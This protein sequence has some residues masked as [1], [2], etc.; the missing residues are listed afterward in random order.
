MVPP[1]NRHRN[2]TSSATALLLAALLHMGCAAPLTSTLLP[3]SHD[4]DT[5]VEPHAPVDPN[6]HSPRANAVRK[7]TGQQPQSQQEAFAGVLKELQEI[8]AIDPDAERQLMADLQEAKPEHYPMIVDAFRTALAYRQQLV[9][10]EQ[11][12][13]AAAE[14]LVVSDADPMVQTA[15]HQSPESARESAERA[16]A[17]QASLAS[18]R[19]DRTARRQEMLAESKGDLHA[20]DTRAANLQRLPVPETSTTPE[21]A[22]LRPAPTARALTPLETSPSD[23]VASDPGPQDAAIASDQT[24]QPQQNWQTDLEAS[25]AQLQRTVSPQP[26]S[27][28]E[29]HDHMRLRTLQLLAGRDEEA[30]RPIPGASPDQQDYW[31]KQLFAMDAYLDSGGKLDDKQRAAAAL[32]ALD[33]ARAKLSELAT[34]QIRNA[35]FVASV[36]GFGAYEPSK[37]KSFQ[38][39]Q[40]VT[41]YAEVEN[42]RSSADEEGYYTS[43]ATSYQVLDKTG[44]RVDGKQFPDVSDRCRNRRRDFHMQYELPLPTRIYPGEYVLELTIT[45]HNSGKIGQTTLPFEIAGESP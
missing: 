21:T 2:R 19:A 32:S 33:E 26:T 1:T 10:R 8:R 3:A 30:Y 11:R 40:K 16:A 44:R 12:E 29:L 38:P 43:L 5:K 9:A 15:S 17:V 24:E 20:S 18:A 45:D 7:A 23:P 34:L 25:I 27:V 42:F 35:A 22:A 37:S 28:A 14:S 41:L 4:K 39:G 13:A 31:S 36:D 6:D